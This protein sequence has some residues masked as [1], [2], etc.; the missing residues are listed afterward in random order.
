M[1]DGL[2]ARLGEDAAASRN[3]NERDGAEHLLEGQRANELNFECV[4]VD[5]GTLV[6]RWVVGQIQNFD[7]LSVKE[8]ERE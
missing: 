7:I 6:R 8:L 2:Q 3:V 5:W 4:A 1:G